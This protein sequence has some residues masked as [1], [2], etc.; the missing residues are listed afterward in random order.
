MHQGRSPARKAEKAAARA[1]A[2]AISRLGEAPGVGAA[3]ACGDLHF[4]CVFT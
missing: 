2:P 3:T 1:L 4:A